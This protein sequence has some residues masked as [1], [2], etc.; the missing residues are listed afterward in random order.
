MVECDSSLCF[1]ISL[2]LVFFEKKVGEQ[3]LYM[4]RTGNLLVLLQNKKLIFLL[5]EGL[6]KQN[7]IN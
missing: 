4:K 1:L 2:F 5:L 3:W 7:L 6:N